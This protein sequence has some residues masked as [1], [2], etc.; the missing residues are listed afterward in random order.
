VLRSLPWRYKW[1]VALAPALAASLPLAIGR[2]AGLWQSLPSGLLAFC[3]GA[4]VAS[5]LLLM[6]WRQLAMRYF[7]RRREADDRMALLALCAN[8]QHKVLL[9]YAALSGCVGAAQA[10]LLLGR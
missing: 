9:G 1:I 2:R 8:M 3:L 4:T 10:L 7:R 5:L 6:L